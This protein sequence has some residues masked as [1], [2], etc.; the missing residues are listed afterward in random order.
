MEAY[1]FLDT[2]QI[3]NMVYDPIKITAPSKQRISLAIGRSRVREVYCTSDIMM[4][5]VGIL[6]SQSYDH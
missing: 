3:G 6:V 4:C 1:L 2:P 5:F